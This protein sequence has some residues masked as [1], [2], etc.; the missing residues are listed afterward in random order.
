MGSPAEAEDH[1]EDETI[2][3]VTI[4]QPFY[5]GKYEVTQAQWRAVM[6]DNPSFFRNCGDTCP[7]EGISWEEVE[8]F[9]EELNARTGETT[10]RLPTE[11]EWEYAARAGTQTRYH[12]GDAES[13]LCQYAN[14]AD[15]SS[16]PKC[17]ATRPVRTVSPVGPPRSGVISPTR[18]GCMICTA[19]SGSGWRTGMETI[20][21]IRSRTLKARPRV[22]AGFGRGGGGGAAPPTRVVW[23]IASAYDT[24]RSQHQPRLPPGTNDSVASFQAPKRRSAAGLSGKSAQ[25]GIMCAGPDA[26]RRGP[27]RTPETRPFERRPHRFPV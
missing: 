12:F 24:E 2:H 26:L 7:V 17:G 10:Y 19:T 3:Q 9:V 5:L 8:T 13:E 15:S 1:E 21:P 4:S 27:T 22:A 11:A 25:K 14:H 18:G 20:P 6:G 16:G 23:S